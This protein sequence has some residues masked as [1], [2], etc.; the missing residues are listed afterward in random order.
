MDMK[1]RMHTNLP[2]K[3]WLD[4]L[5]DERAEC[6]RKIYEFNNCHPDDRDKMDKILRSLLGK[7]GEG[8]HIEQPFRCDYGSNIE[9]GDNFFANYNLVILDVGK[10][11]IG[12]NVMLAPNVA[13]YTAGHPVHYIPR[14]TGYEYGIDITIGD[15]VWRCYRCGERCDKGHSRQ[16][17]SR[18]KSCKGYP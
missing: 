11:K 10:V 2:Y 5:G 13:I 9:V 1:Q 12:D 4:G 3:A 16:L 14:N 6:R 18:R 17:H 7:A 15:N 8:L